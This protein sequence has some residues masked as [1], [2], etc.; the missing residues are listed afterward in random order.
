MALVV[1]CANGSD[2][3]CEYEEDEEDEENVEDEEEDDDD[4]ES[5]K[6]DNEDEESGEEVGSLTS[7]AEERTLSLT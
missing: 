1:D 3:G 4:E 2:E 6:E 5:D 7:G